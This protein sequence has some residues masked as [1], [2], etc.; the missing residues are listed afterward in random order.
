MT[1]EIP[2]TIEVSSYVSK[3]QIELGKD[4]VAI[5]IINEGNWTPTFGFNSKANDNNTIETSRSFSLGFPYTL[6]GNKLNID[7]LSDGAGDKKYSVITYKK[8]C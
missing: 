6:A 4:V 3:R 7:F 1:P 2:V 8:T 5:T